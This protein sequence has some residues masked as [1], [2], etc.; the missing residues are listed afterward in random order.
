MLEEQTGILGRVER[1][2]KHGLAVV[3]V[4]SWANAVH[5]RCSPDRTESQV[6]ELTLSLGR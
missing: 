1:Y 6:T 2:L 3:V 4:A 5:M